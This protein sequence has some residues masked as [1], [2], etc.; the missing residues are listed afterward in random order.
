MFR[1]CTL[2]PVSGV[3]GTYAKT[4]LLETEEAFL[5][6]VAAFWLAVK[7]LCLQS[8]NALFRRTFQLQAKQTPIV[9]K[10][11]KL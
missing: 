9:S 8:L 2:V 5:L 1:F 3:Q 10:K 7:L 4:T 6:T 11:L